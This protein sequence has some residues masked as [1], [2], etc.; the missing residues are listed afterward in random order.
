M[1]ILTNSK[2]YK[3]TA[4]RDNSVKIVLTQGEGSSAANPNYNKTLNFQLYDGL[5]H[6]YYWG[7]I[8]LDTRDFLGHIKDHHHGIIQK[9]CLLNLPMVWLDKIKL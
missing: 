2:L 4:W 6:W 5:S 3:L 8:S 1:A 9:N 7:K